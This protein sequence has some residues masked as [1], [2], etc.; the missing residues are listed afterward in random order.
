MTIET[1]LLVT[2]A[3]IFPTYREFESLQAL[4]SSIVPELREF[5]AVIICDDTGA[6][7]EELISKDVSKIFKNS[8]CRVYFSFS[9]AKS[10]RGAAVFRGMELATQT[11]PHLK[12]IVEADSDGSHRPTDIIRIL[13]SEES[14]FRIGSRYLQ[15][16]K[17]LG[18]PLS[19]RLFSALLN[20]L[21]PKILN[22]ECSDA[23]NG[24][25]RYSISCV[26]ELLERGITNTGF[27]Y[28]SE[29]A[30]VLRKAGFTITE[31]PITFVNRT[32]G[33]SSVGLKEIKDSLVGI[34]SLL[35]KTYKNK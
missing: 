31:T 22:L 19:R 24:L 8:N 18:W 29:Q 35:R 7:F 20:K 14:D 30:V 26:R 17:I 33:E 3:L 12:Y 16:S 32:H 15:E 28:L 4:L 1:N 21:I 25:R 9:N 5:D 10:G 27:I 11:F 2:N 13:S 6:E 23:T 34:F